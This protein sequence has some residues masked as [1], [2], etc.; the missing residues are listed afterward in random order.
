MRG[1]L[2]ERAISESMGLRTYSTE[3]RTFRSYAREGAT[4]LYRDGPARWVIADGLYMTERVIL[5]IDASGRVIDRRGPFLTAGFVEIKALAGSLSISEGEHQL[6]GMI[7]VASRTRDAADPEAIASVTIVT[8][9]DVRISNTILD[10]AR[11]RRVDVWHSKALYDTES[12][13]IISGPSE[14]RFRVRL[15]A[16]PVLDYNPF[17]NQGTPVQLDR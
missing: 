15:P 1:C 5:V 7:D 8:T 16:I 11:E 12:G 4:R 13:A 2:F 10:Y 9:S 6:R 17:P 14:N 3:E